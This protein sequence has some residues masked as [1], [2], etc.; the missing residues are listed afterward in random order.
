MP[1]HATINEVRERLSKWVA[2]HDPD[3]LASS[4]EESLLMRD[5]KLA[6]CR[7]EIGTVVATWWIG[8]STVEIRSPIRPDTLLLASVAQPSRAA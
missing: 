3:S 6:G 7:F 2:Q 5:G 4:C 8:E 1:L